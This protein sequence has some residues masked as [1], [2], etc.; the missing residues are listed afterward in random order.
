MRSWRM[1]VVVALVAV[2]AGGTVAGCHSSTSHGTH[3]SKK[4]RSR[5]MSYDAPGTGRT[6]D[7]ITAGLVT[8]A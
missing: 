8:R 3:K 6:S 1:P 5:S 4:S 7:A 2:V